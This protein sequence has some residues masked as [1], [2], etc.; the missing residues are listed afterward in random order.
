[1]EMKLRRKIPAGVKRSR[2]YAEHVR[3]QEQSARFRERAELNDEL[4]GRTVLVFELF[5]IHSL[6]PAWDRALKR[7]E[8]VE[9]LNPQTQIW[10]DDKRGKRR[11]GWDW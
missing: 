4:F 7:A 9:R 5:L 3:W 11:W 10:P 8:D 6:R 1:M 2:F